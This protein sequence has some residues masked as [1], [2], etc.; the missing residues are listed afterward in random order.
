MP[1]EPSQL[2][3]LLREFVRERTEHLKPVPRRATC[4]CCGNSVTIAQQHNLRWWCRQRHQYKSGDIS[5]SVTTMIARLA[6]RGRYYEQHCSQERLG[7]YW[8]CNDCVD[9]GRAIPADPG[10][11]EWCDCEPYLA[12]FDEERTC[13]D[14]GRAFVFHKEEQQH[15]YETLRFWV[16]SRPIRCRACNR[17]RKA[18][19]KIAT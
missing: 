19:R 18:R 15:W 5:E 9:T 12:Y 14:C 2:R 8:A 1:N 17:N 11:Q 10:K 6:A 7:L 4:P 3:K 13:V 16:W